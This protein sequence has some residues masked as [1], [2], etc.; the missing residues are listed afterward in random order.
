MKG[1]WLDLPKHKAGAELA[2]Y[3]AALDQ[4]MQGRLRN[5]E[6][7]AAVY[8]EQ[9][10]TSLRPSRQRSLITP[11]ESR[12]ANLTFNMARSLCETEHA[13]ITE[14]T[15]RPTFLTEDGN[16]PDQDKAIELQHAVDGVFS[17]LRAYET[18]ERAELDKCVLGVGV[19]KVHHV[20]GRPAIDK[21]LIT[22]IL[23]DEDL[24]GTGQEPRAIIH[25]QE[26]SR[27]D[28]HV[29][30]KNAPAS[31]H[32]AIDNA[33]AIV[34]AVLDERR[35]DLIVAYDAY[36]LPIDVATGEA[37][38]D[39]WLRG[40]HGIAIENHDALIYDKEWKSPRS[41]F[42]FQHWQRPTRGFYG[43]GVIEQVLGMQVEINRFYRNVGIALK[44]WGV[45][46]AFVPDGSKIDLQK[47]VN[48]PMGRFIPYD[49]TGGGV[50]IMWNGLIL[51][52]EVMQWLQFQMENGYRVTGIPQNTA[53]A[54]REQGIPSA[55]G[56]REISQKGASR[57]APQSK[58]YER[59]IVDGAWRVDDIL[60]E[61]KEDG[62]KLVISTA[63]QGALHKVDLDAALSLTPGT[64]KV[65]VF[66]GNFLSRHP[67]SKVEEVQELAKSEIFTPEEV[68]Q[69]IPMPDVTAA[70]GKAA[71]VKG[72]YRR[73]IANTIK[74]G[75]YTRP[76]AFFPQKELGV[77]LY[78]EA[79]FENQSAGVATDRLQ[80]LRDWL[81][82]MKDI[83]QP[84][85]PPTPADQ[86]QAMAPQAA[87]S[88]AIAPPQPAE[89]TS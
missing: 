32:A 3:A 60:R 59:A 45:P 12:N 69:L 86:S 70:L 63:D 73:Q 37:Q 35:A 49:A 36:A 71:D 20:N 16:R 25:R 81:T 34:P 5:A 58:Q 43:I 15:P 24:I 23:V 7:F 26:V 40:R 46:T 22:D 83:L 33:P 9:L 21:P 47:M 80:L 48:N 68:K 77:K 6:I 75:I 17:D 4:R 88:G 51:T 27:R 57:L 50:P 89:A 18:Y 84:P 76:E 39:E 79:L 54:E 55:R 11:A 29:W 41:P 14:S 61:L 53:F 19:T 8:S 31:V 10:E 38:V 44:M 87:P 52:P 2:Q 28:M 64:Y 82:A 65:D 42:Q 56:Q 30:F 13:T 67:A 72:I 66:A 78:S 1:S 62:A 74:K 85:V